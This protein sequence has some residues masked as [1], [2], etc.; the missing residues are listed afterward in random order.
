MG[1]LAFVGSHA[2]NGVSAL[3]TGLLRQTVFRDLDALYPGRISNKTNGITFRRWLHRANPGLTR[4]LVDALGERVLRD[5]EAL[6]DLAPHADDARL[7]GRFAAQRRERKEALARIMAERSGVAIDPD[8]LFDV[9]VKRIHEYKRQ[10]LNILHAVALYDAIRAEPGAGL[11]A[12]G[13]DPGR[14]GG[15]ELSPG[16]ADHPPRARRGAD[17]QRRPGGRAGG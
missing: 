1:H 3:H 6:A 11:G 4:L 12:E 14:Q 2:V 13:Q 16:Q 15:A 10:L 17:G 9:Q 5:A 8:A 7:P